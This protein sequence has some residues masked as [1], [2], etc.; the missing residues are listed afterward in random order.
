[1]KLMLKRHGIKCDQ[2]NSH[3]Y[4]KFT[5]KDTLAQAVAEIVKEKEVDEIKLV[6][7]IG[8]LDKEKYDQY[9]STDLKRLSYA[10]CALDIAG[11]MECFND[12]AKQ[13]L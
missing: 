12:I 2:L 11:A 5:S 1:M 9:L 4:L 7:G 8:N 6:S 13:I 10:Y 3:L